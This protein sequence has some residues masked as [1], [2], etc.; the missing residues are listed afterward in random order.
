M[1]VML[2][3]IQNARG[4]FLDKQLNWVGADDAGALFHSPH[5][6]VALNQL[7]ELNA[8]DIHLRARVLS[9]AADDRGRPRLDAMAA[10]SAA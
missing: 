3:L 2:Y 5:K 7:L 10:G 1:T 6:D 9:C 8:R 4:D